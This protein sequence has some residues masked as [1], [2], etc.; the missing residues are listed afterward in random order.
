MLTS[1]LKTEEVVLTVGMVVACCVL[2]SGAANI[3]ATVIIVVFVIGFWILQTRQFMGSARQL[4]LRPVNIIGLL[5]DWVHTLL[6]LASLG[7]MLYWRDN[8]QLHDVDTL[9]AAAL[10]WMGLKFLDHLRGFKR[11]AFLMS[12]LQ[13]I[14]VD[15]LPFTAVLCFLILAFTAVFYLLLRDSAVEY[16]WD[17]GHD[18]SNFGASSV[19]VANMAL[20]EFDMEY[21]RQAPY[22]IPATGMLM[23]FIFIVPVVMLNALIAI[24]SNSY[25]KVKDEELER[26]FL[27][28]AQLVVQLET[29]LRRGPFTTNNYNVSHR[30]IHVLSM[31]NRHLAADES[32]SNDD[33]DKER[34]SNA[35]TQ[36]QDKMDTMLELLQAQH[37]VV[38]KQHEA[39]ISV[40]EAL[41]TLDS[42]LDGKMNEEEVGS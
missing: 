33:V 13:R 40:L 36:L 42:K 7:L 18:F 10:F 12:M 23:L 3:T 24:M 37:S 15:M 29:I 41:R 30:Y 5:L 16:A 11:T 20:G 22:V 38:L 39:N 6:A 17:H 8:T 28:R 1:P 2:V 26:R 32:H 34:S 4:T 35:D 21:F 9:Q 27:E 25:D 31:D 14:L 19:A